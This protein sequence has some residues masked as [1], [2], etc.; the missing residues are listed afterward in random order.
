MW[1]NELK[2]A[3]VEQNPQSIEKL[4]NNFPEFK[5]MTQATEALYLLNEA[6]LLMQTLK[7]ETSSSMQQIK[8]NIDYLR[9]TTSE[10]KQNL[11]IK[12]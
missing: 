8:N 5:E 3:I 1:L 10:Q 12:T 7:N 4:L 2:I 9:S 11:D 6:S